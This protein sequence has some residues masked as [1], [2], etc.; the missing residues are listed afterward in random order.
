M[1]YYDFIKRLAG[2]VNIPEIFPDSDMDIAVAVQH[3]GRVHT[4][5]LVVSGDVPAK[6]LPTE[7]R[8]LTT[9]E[10]GTLNY[11]ELPGNLLIERFDHGIAALLF[12]GNP[13][14]L[15]AGYSYSFSHL[16][17]AVNVFQQ[18]VPHATLRVNEHRVYFVNADSVRI[19]Y[20]PRPDMPLPEDFV[21][22]DVPLHGNDIEV[23]IQLVSSHLTGNTGGDPQ[24]AAMHQQFAMLYQNNSVGA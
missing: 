15:S 24:L 12:N 10:Q 9:R 23:A 8:S 19:Q 2:E 16:E 22:K 5:V 17:A 20:V 4:A 14:D 7:E 11:A 1:T 18:D 3:L 21:E 13:Y 6:R